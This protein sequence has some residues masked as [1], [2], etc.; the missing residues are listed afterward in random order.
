MRIA[1]ATFLFAPVLL[2]AQAGQR[3]FLE[4]CAPCHGAGGH[5]GFAAN[6]AVPRLPHAPDDKAL[7]NLVKNGFPGTDMTPAFGI[8]DNEVRQIV[9]YVRSLGRAPAQKVPGNARRGEQLYAG[10]GNCASCH[11]LRGSGGRQGPDLSEIGARRGVSH[12]RQSLTDPEAALPHDF[13][14]VHITTAQGRNLTGIR[15]NEDSFSIQ[16]RDLDGGL[17]SFSKTSLSAVRKDF[18]KTTMPSYKSFSAAELDDIVSFL[19]TLR[20]DL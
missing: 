19:V 14:L 2:Y 11:M 13:L 10:K 16:L 12:L 15:L 3:L 7:A 1:V 20:G 9:T 8:T 17:H 6:L 4:H 5:D 18:G